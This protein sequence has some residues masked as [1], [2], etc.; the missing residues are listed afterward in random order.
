MAHFATLKVELEVRD[1][2]G[3]LVCGFPLKTWNWS[4]TAPSGASPSPNEFPPQVETYRIAVSSNLTLTIPNGCKY[5]VILPDQ[6]TSLIL[7]DPA[8]TGETIIA[9]TP[10]SN[11]LPAPLMFPV[12]QGTTTTLVLRNGNASTVQNLT[13][14]WL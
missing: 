10:S 2:A 14:Y 12:D 4:P 8:E 1:G 7:R 6:F 5:V 11:P 13:V 9:F 3:H